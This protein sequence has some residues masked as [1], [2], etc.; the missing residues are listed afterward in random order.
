MKRRHK[1]L[2]L[3]LLLL[4]GVAGWALSRLE[5]GRMAALKK[6]EAVAAEAAGLRVAKEVSDRQLEAAAHEND[7]L[8]EEIERVRAVAPKAKVIERTRWQTREVE[9]P[10][11]RVIP[12]DRIIEVAPEC[13]ELGELLGNVAF[14]VA[15]TEARLETK[16]GNLFAVGEVEVWREAP[17][18]REQLFS[19]P[20]ESP[21]TE[22]L[23]Q[24]QTAERPWKLDLL[25]GVT[26]GPGWALGAHW[27]RPRRFIL[28][29]G[30][31]GLILR[32]NALP[33]AYR[34]TQGVEAVGDNWTVAAGVSWTIR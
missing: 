22:V 8:A 5:A 9:V 14:S 16:A 28:P 13:A 3:I 34:A 7:A 25:A 12:V 31:W 27:R 2:I 23:R 15:G 11:D 29:D 26:T 18:P 10:V 30:A 20:W 1:V 6:A 19:A 24:R 33:V 32:D 4:L 21:L 17:P